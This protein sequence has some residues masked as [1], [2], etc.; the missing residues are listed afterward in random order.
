MKRSILLFFLLALFSQLSFGQEKP[1]I[2]E[3]YF[4]EDGLASELIYCITEDHNGLI[5]L[6]TANGLSRFDGTTFKKMYHSAEGFVSGSSLNHHIIK[7]LL[8]D[9]EG[10]IW[11]GTQGGGLNRIDSKT[12]EIT[13]YL[14]SDTTEES[15]NHNE[16]LS[17][18]QDPKGNIWIGTED[19]LAILNPADGSIYNYYENKED[20]HAIYGKAIL[21]IKFSAEGIAYLTAWGGPVHSVDLSANRDL[22]QLRFERLWHKDEQSNTPKDDATWGLL[23]DSKGRLWAG[24]FGQGVIMRSKEE[25]KFKFLSPG[26]SSKI[27]PNIFSL[28]EDHSGQIWIGSSKGLNILNLEGEDLSLFELNEAKIRTFYSRSGDG[29]IPANQIRDIYVARNHV[30]WVATEGGLA[31]YDPYI[32]RFNAFLNSEN[33]ELKDGVSALCKDNMGN[34]WAANSIGELICL[35]EKTG[36]KQVVDYSADYRGEISVEFIRRLSFINKKIWIGTKKGL[37]I[38]DPINFESKRIEIHPENLNFIPDISNFT[39]GPKGRVWIATYQ[40]IAKVDPI[41]MDFTY[42]QS[43]LGDPNG[44]SANKINDIVF[45]VEGE[46]WASSEDSGLIEISF[47]PQGEIE[48]KS[49]FPVP[50]D[51]ESLVNRNLRSLA[52]D[53]EKIW[54][55]GVQGLFKFNIVQKKF[56]HYGMEAGLYSPY[57]TSLNIDEAGNV[58]GGSNTGIT[59]LDIQLGHFSH[60]GKANGIP[61]INHYD[62]SSYQDENGTLYYSG[63]NGFIRFD[64]K[65]LRASSPT[66]LIM[67]DGLRLANEPVWVNKADP[68]TNEVI[69]TE[70]LDNLKEVQLSYQHDI[71]TI[72]FSIINFRFAKDGQVAY[73]LRNL[74]EKWHN[75]R[76]GRS[77]TYTNLEAG[78]YYFEIKASNHE[79]KWNADHPPLKIVILPPF[80]ETWY[81][82]LLV[83][84]GFILA[85]VG[86]YRY[87]TAKIKSQNRILQRRVDE[88]TQEL[89]MAN[90]RE[91]QARYLAEEA[92]LAKSEFLA[93]MSHEIRTPM[94]G[95]LGMAELLDED[96]L[97]PDQ[98]DYVKTI[99]S[100]GENLLGII[101]DILDF[102]K[103]ESG[104]L[105]LEILPID[106]QNLVE[107]VVG[108][109]GSKLN[110]KPLELLYEI[111]EDVPRVVSGDPLRLRQILINLV[112]NAL[113]FTEKGEIIVKV[114]NMTNRQ[115]VKG[116][117]CQIQFAVQDS[118]I[119]IPLDKQERLFQAFSQVD[120]STTRK[121]GGTGLGLAISAKLARLMG[122]EMQVKSEEGRGSTFSFSINSQVLELE[123]QSKQ[124]FDAQV[125]HD[126]R[127]LIVEDNESH[128]LLLSKRLQ[129]WGIEPSLAR[130]GKVA[131]EIIQSNDNFDLILTDLFMPELDGLELAKR[132]KS[133]GKEIP[134]VLITAL[135]SAKTMRGTGLFAKVLAKPVKQDLL[136]RSICEAL[137]INTLSHLEVELKGQAFQEVAPL[138]KELKILLVEDNPVNRKLAL[139]M[140]HKLGYDPKVA[141]NGL[142]GFEAVRD[143]KFEIVLMDVQMPVLDGLNATRKIRSEIPADRQPTIIAMTANA[144]Q[145]D[146]EMCIQAGMNDYISKP[147]R[148]GELANK[149]AEYSFKETSSVD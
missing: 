76:F 107:E 38:L 142:E 139:R 130:N 126:K 93:N 108:L 83:V 41:T 85:I 145:G 61:S 122:G 146:R 120:A 48:S 19:G 132:L 63:N 148:M 121:Y 58:W 104:K 138:N 35:N 7:S 77:A 6:G 34:I 144:M 23:S 43:D 147:F 123:D 18:A 71:I 39:L 54:I 106:L 42:Y 29:H 40:G 2:F 136:A 103:I 117:D 49:Y 28:V 20:Q 79:G 127:I 100:S 56:T 134:L 84:I 59:C 74:E 99:R 91:S 9:K 105:E 102:S 78:T 72:D 50:E 14:H 31:K 69:L 113:K 89:A 3:S 92:N 149:I 131:L 110:E 124:L 67:F 25:K 8:T 53:N 22:S 116:N 109:F 86:A 75:E 11:V 141:T 98:K 87:R 32:S 90:A 57:Q 44:L 1:F 73:R 10:N 4:L 17:L 51:L 133:L 96:S 140:M 95:V 137:G 55:G 30:V 24:T 81:F 12:E 66:P 52:I 37:F 101:N 80:W 47:R 68:I 114:S 65:T 112:G 64:P 125:L 143:G 15:I 82:R 115:T 111:Q 27:A 129:S 33:P 88:R 97:R 94:N 60:F 119:G 45:T 128:L 16:V 46:M 118:G 5:W 135:G 70:K 36:K 62:G 21:N 26:E 13:Y